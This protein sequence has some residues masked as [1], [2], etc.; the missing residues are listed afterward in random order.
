MFGINYGSI[1]DYDLQQYL[2][3]GRFGTV[4]YGTHKT[5]GERVG[6]TTIDKFDMNLHKRTLRNDLK[7]LVQVSH[8]NILN[9]LG[10]CEDQSKLYLITEVPGVELFD[11][12]CSEY[13][14]GYSEKQACE[15]TRQMVSAVQHLHSKGLI[16]GDIRPENIRFTPPRLETDS[17]VL[18][19]ADARIAKNWN[20]ERV[21]WHDY[22]APEVLLNDIRGD[23]FAVDM[24]GIGVI[25]YVMLCGFCPFA[26]DNLPAKFRAITQGKYTFPSPYW[27]GVSEDAKDLLR[28]ILVV[29]PL[30]RATEEE[31]L[32]HPWIASNEYTNTTMGMVVTG[33]V[34]GIAANREKPDQRHWYTLRK[35]ETDR[36][37]DRQASR[38]C[39]RLSPEVAHK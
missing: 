21:R 12:I 35:G 3:K 18:K 37:T 30:L 38:G 27:D 2:D 7:I 34:A 5:T 22:S 20:W 31:V 32:S 9:L 4:R 25:L 14:N 6:V 10:A 24:W 33:E 28:R 39:R 26:D 15:L 1:D 36:Q 16:H 29:N 8:E 23:T 17:M 13:P 19:I 11:C